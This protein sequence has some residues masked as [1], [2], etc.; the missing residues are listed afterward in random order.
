MR[1]RCANSI[2]IF[3][4]SRREVRPSTILRFG[5]PCRE[6]PRK[7]SAAPSVMPTWGSTGTSASIAIAL[8]GDVKHRGTV[9]YQRSSRGEGHAA[10][11][12]V[13]VT[14]MVLGEVLA[15]EGPVCASRLVEHYNVRFDP[16]LVEQP[17]EHLGRAIAAVTEEPA[18][19]EIEP[20]ER[21]IFSP[22][23]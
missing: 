23:N 14:C 10:G 18:R 12:A 11:T 15:R 2:S 3:L 19:I 6:R 7:S 13:D 8:A 4:R 9:V 5:A 22:A 21:A 17:A 20:F 16:M 1:L